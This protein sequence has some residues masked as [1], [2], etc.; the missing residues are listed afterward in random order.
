MCYESEV[1]DERNYEVHILDQKRSE[2]NKRLVIE[3]VLIGSEGVKCRLR[4]RER[5]RWNLKDVR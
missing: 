4:Q 1:S 2:S 5:I 3:L